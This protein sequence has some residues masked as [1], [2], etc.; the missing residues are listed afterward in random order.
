MLRYTDVRDTT[1]C[2]MKCKSFDGCKW[3]T[4][5]VYDHR[6]NYNCVLYEGCKNF[7]TSYINSLSGE[8][9][10]P[11]CERVGKCLTSTVLGVKFPNSVSKCLKV[12]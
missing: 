2:L 4:F 12:L 11:V 8:V 6:H 1:E 10:C 3:F 7:S 5:H 9:L